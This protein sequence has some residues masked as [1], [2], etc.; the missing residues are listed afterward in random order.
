MQMDS[1]AHIFLTGGTGFFGK[2][3]LRHWAQQETTGQ[4]M[5]Q[6]TLLS[7][8][9][10]RFCIQYPQLAAHPWLHFAQ[11]DICNANSLPH[12]I[13]FTHILHAATDSTVGPQLSPLQRY[14][15]IVNGTRNVLDLAVSC[16]AQRFLLI[17]SGAVYGTQPVH[18]ERTPEDWYGMPDPLNTANAYG[19]AK[20]MAEHLC[21]LYTQAH[22]LH[23]AVARCFAFVGPDLPLD[24]HFAIGNFIRDALQ[25][26]CISVQGDGSPLRSYM[27]Q[28]DLAVWL[29]ELLCRGS[30]GHAYNVGS[31]EAISIADLAHL[32][33]D[34]L[35]P[36]KPVHILGE[37]RDNGLRS[38]YVPSIDK[39]ANELGLKITVPLTEAIRKTAA[40]HIGNS[41]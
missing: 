19:V 29:L 13:A 12:G 22:G 14:E 39:A 26:E 41:A 7:R 5:P 25:A 33:R 9:P 36:R 4:L 37:R 1:Q 31:P 34:T 16:G 38:L 10:E 35:A 30:G 27:E 28:S 40:A 20:R 2:A 8:D 3:L 21:A 11:G 32:V 15:Q 6:V 24:V 18:L 23:T 17:S